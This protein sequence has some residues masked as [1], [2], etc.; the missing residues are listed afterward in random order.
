MSELGKYVKNNSKF[1]SIQD[2]DTVTLI[3]KGFEIIDD[4]FRPGNKTV[5]YLFQDP[6]TG[7]SLPWAKSSNKVA[8]QMDKINTGELISIT[9]MGE[10]MGT[11]YRIRVLKDPKPLGNVDP[12]ETTP[13]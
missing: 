13:F 1:L 7:K 11:T 6:E 8:L 10:G 2:G 5:S 12:D 3:Y 4:R 9:R